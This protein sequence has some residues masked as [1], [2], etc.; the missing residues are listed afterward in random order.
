MT[1]I[2]AIAEGEMLGQRLDELRGL[3][4]R[5]SPGDLLLHDVI[6]LIAILRPVAERV[7]PAAGAS[8]T[9]PRLRVVR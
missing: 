2:V 4:A 6:A 8:V 3:L 5:C 7:E 1:D 9:A